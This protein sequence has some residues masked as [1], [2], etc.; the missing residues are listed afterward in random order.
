[1]SGG[2]GPTPEYLALAQ[3]DSIQILALQ[4]EDKPTVQDIQQLVRIKALLLAG[5]LLRAGEANLFQAHRA[6][7]FHLLLGG[8]QLAVEDPAALWIADGEGMGWPPPVLELDLQV[9]HCGAEGSAT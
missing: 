6:K 1:M 9:S 3:A 7:E 4:L 5:D 8:L 2:T